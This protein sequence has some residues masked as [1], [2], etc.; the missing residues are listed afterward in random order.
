MFQPNSIS[1]SLDFWGLNGAVHNQSVLMTHT[2][3]YVQSEKNPG[4]DCLTFGDSSSRYHGNGNRGSS[5]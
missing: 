3:K 5:F 4:S 2:S 1:L